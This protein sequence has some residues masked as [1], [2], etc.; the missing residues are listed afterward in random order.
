MTTQNCQM[1]VS[2]QIKIEARQIFNDITIS[3]M[4]CI[5]KAIFFS[6]VCESNEYLT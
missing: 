1:L 4:L 6:S 3:H 5:I 2:F